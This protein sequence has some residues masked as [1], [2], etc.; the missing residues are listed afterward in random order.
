MLAFAGMDDGG[1]ERAVGIQFQIA[2][3]SNPGA[4]L[5]GPGEMAD[6][7]LQG[8]NAQLFEKLRLFGANALQKGNG[9]T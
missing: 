2:N 7:I 1:P 4:V 9:I 8:I 6:Q 3:F 5:I